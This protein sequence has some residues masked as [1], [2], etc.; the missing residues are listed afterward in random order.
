M[1]NTFILNISFT[2]TDAVGVLLAS[3]TIDTPGKKT[4]E[5]ANIKHSND[6]QQCAFSTYNT[7]LLDILFRNVQ[8]RGISFI[9]QKLLQ[10]I[11]QLNNEF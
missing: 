5:R 9:Y 6:V 11:T 10:Y 1:D 8:S 3:F 2:N 4:I 7:V